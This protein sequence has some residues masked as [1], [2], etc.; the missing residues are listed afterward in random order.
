[1]FGRDHAGF[2]VDTNLNYFTIRDTEISLYEIG[3]MKPGLPTLCLWFYVFSECGT[4]EG[5]KSHDND[6]KRCS[7]YQWLGSIFRV[8]QSLSPN[9]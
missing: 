2:K 1:M 8:F 4:R 7:R 5:E 9:V 6:T 3:T